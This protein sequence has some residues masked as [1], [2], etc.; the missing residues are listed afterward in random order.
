MSS[1]LMRVKM[2]ALSAKRRERAREDRMMDATVGRAAALAG[3]F[4]GGRVLHGRTVGPMPVSFALGLAATALELA[5]VGDGSIVAR[6]AY[7]AAHGAATGEAAIQ[8]MMMAVQR[9]DDA[10]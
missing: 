8:G 9:E 10:F 2:A 6:T 3:G 5:G 1:K 4:V 7:D